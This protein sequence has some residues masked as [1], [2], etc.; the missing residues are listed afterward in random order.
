MASP[1]NSLMDRLPFE[2]LDDI[3]RSACID[4]GKTARS[5][6]L[7]CRRV[8]AITRPHQFRSVAVAGQQQ[9][10]ALLIELS[11]QDGRDRRVFHLFIAVSDPARP[12]LAPR[13][14][15]GMSIRE[16]LDLYEEQWRVLFRLVAPTVR[17]LTVLSYHPFP[18]RFYTPFGREESILSFPELTHF[19]YQHASRRG[20]LAVGGGPN[21]PTSSLQWVRMPK[22]QVLHSSSRA[23]SLYVCLLI[24][25]VAR[26]SPNL[27]HIM[28]W[29]FDIKVS[30]IA[31]LKRLLGVLP[32][33]Y[34][35][36]PWG[37]LREVVW[38]TQPLY[39]AIRLSVRPEADLPRP[40]LKALHEVFDNGERQC[41]VLPSSAQETNYRDFMDEWLAQQQN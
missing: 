27:E 37:G 10:V 14:T 9:T 1:I 39:K 28:L 12:A 41:H 38:K 25:D 8:S 31:A 7:L 40:N 36:E 22:L 5:L 33:I 11:K 20:L 2:I 3:V 21:S 30:E 6:S 32:D 24:S 34:N 35:V 26:H 19:T 18:G 17:T 4:G 15:N 23:S 13:Q 16:T 29:D